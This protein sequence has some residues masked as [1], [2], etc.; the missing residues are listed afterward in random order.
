MVKLNAFNKPLRLGVLKLKPV[1]CSGV[2]MSLPGAPKL[3]GL[4][5]DL[6]VVGVPNVADV[7]GCPSSEGLSG[8]GFCETPPNTKPDC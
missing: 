2:C 7:V 8:C 3:N 6:L 1:F 5:D 4:S